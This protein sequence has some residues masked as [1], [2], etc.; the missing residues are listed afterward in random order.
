MSKYHKIRWQQADTEELARVVRNFNAKVD[1]LAKK[2]PLN[3]NVLPDKVSV[4]QLKQLINTRKDLNRELNMLKRFSKRGAEEIVIADDTKYNVKI[5]KWQRTEMKR[6]VAMINRRR[7]KR[8]EQLQDTEMTSRGESLGYTRG[9]FGMGKVTE[10]SLRPMN[11]FYHTMSQSDLKWKWKAIMKESQSDYFDRKDYQLR[12]NYIKA[13]EQNFN[14]NDKDIKEIVDAI[15]TM[16]IK[17]FLNTFESE[18]GTFEFAYPP[19]E[20]QSDAY[21]TGEKTKWIRKG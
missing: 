9:Q 7:Q 20:E 1:R 15:R 11:V 8:L 10:V 17:D 6:K 13:L 4:R 18:G 3:K 5:T 14:P 12:E 16:D 19:N 2:N 21:K